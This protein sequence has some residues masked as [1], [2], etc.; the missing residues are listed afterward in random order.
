MAL[1]RLKKNDKAL[2][3]IDGETVEVVVIS[4]NNPYPNIYQVT[5][6]KGKWGWCAEEDLKP[7]NR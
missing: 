5:D 2:C 4:N 6:G 1:P 3:D 7:V